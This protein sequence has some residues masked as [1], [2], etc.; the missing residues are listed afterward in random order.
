V[1][2]SA[3]DKRSQ[4]V[5]LMENKTFADLDVDQMPIIA[6][7]CGHFFTVETLDG[8]MGIDTFYQRDESGQFVGLRNLR[9]IE[10]SELE[11]LSCVCPNCRAPISQIRRYGR[12]NNALIVRYASRKHAQKFAQGL[13]KRMEDLQSLLERKSLLELQKCV[14]ESAKYCGLV[15]ETPIRRCLELAKVAEER[16]TAPAD[17]CASLDLSAVGDDETSVQALGRICS[18]LVV[19]G[20]CLLKTAESKSS[21]SANEEQMKH[22]SKINGIITE[23][24]TFCTHHKLKSSWLK[25][26]QMYVVSAKH[27]HGYGSHA[28]RDSLSSTAS[29]YISGLESGVHFEREQPDVIRALRKVS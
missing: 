29:E 8:V 6:L 12:V 2:C 13:A 16:Q 28:A 23:L 19:C 9:S 7:S 15:A 24:R 11:E 14:N 5:D 20:S 18:M 3:H 26:V 21:Q 1:E 27:L 4:V 10:F 17:P 22:I 25:A